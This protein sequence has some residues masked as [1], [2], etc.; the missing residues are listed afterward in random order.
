MQQDHEQH[1]G[2]DKA[3]RAAQMRRIF[4]TLIHRPA[5][6]TRGADWLIGAVDRQHARNVAAFGWR[7][8]EQLRAQAFADASDAP[9]PT[10]EARES[11]LVAFITGA[12]K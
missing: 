7:E 2:A 8:A 5:L 4:T 10:G 6:T 3:A 12:T 9:I 1:D 11:D